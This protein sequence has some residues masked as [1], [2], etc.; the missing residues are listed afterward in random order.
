MA[1]LQG[2]DRFEG[3]STLRTWLFGILINQARK[4]A[5]RE[6]RTMAYEP[7]RHSDAE[8]GL[9]PERFMPADGRW[10]GH[11]RLDDL[12]VWPRAWE[13]LPENRL[14]SEEV[15]GEIAKALDPLPP[16]Q[17]IV[18][19]LRE[20]SDANQRVLL[21]RARSRVRAHLEAYLDE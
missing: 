5:S 21:H 17:R 18:F 4:I 19:T 8:L 13:G 3:R 16:A 15:C 9:D 2:L 10:A 11:W 20:I 12:T 1:F 7:A 6:R 14:L